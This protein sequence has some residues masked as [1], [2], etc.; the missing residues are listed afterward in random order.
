MGLIHEI[1]AEIT[2]EERR[3][4]V[5][6]YATA[7]DSDQRIEFSVMSI[8]DLLRTLEEIR[9]KLNISLNHRHRPMICIPNQGLYE[10]SEVQILLEKVRDA[11]TDGTLGVHLESPEEILNALTAEMIL[12]RGGPKQ[13][14][15]FRGPNFANFTRQFP[16]VDW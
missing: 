8:P 7:L 5:V 11:D 6:L 4:S 9:A 12:L 3:N 1:N 16:D 14:R 15:Y 10:Q 2:L 13:Q